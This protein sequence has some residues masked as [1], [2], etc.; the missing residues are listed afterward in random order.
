MAVTIKDVARLAGVSPASVCRALATPERVRPETRNRVER[1]AARLGYRPNPIAR[2]LS[3]GRTGNLG[4]IVPDIAN[5]FFPSVVKA[6]QARARELDHAV[7]LADTDEDPILEVDLIRQLAKQVDGFL[8]CA[9]RAADEDLRSLSDGTPVVI[10]NRRVGAIPSVVFDNIDSARQAV[11]HL[12]ALGHRRIA[13]VA[14]PRT[15]WVNRERLRGLRTAAGAAGVEL[16]EIGN[17]SPTLDGGAAAA[18]TLLAAD[19]TAAVAY[20]D[21]VALGVLSRL[22]ARGVEVPARISLVG[23]D[24][25][26]TTDL[27][28]PPLTTVAGAKTQLGRAGIDL[29]I[30]LL[31]DQQPPVSTRRT[32]PTQL[33]VRASTTTAPEL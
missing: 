16:V 17:V 8:L 13:Y 3:T 12:V 30:T 19:V 22:R 11:T 26:P 18:D 15:S 2:G 27:V 9:A 31:Q 33:I 7:F 1:A 6:A 5:P 29:L 28:D 4:L 32:L 10:L 20:N 25:I 23:F 14:G 24:D 21:L